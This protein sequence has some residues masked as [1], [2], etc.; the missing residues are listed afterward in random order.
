M[1]E[2][3]TCSGL[4]SYIRRPPVDLAGSRK[5]PPSLSQLRSVLVHEN[6]RKM[7]AKLGQCI[8]LFFWEPLPCGFPQ[9]SDLFRD[10]GFLAVFWGSGD[11]IRSIGALQSADC[12]GLIRSVWIS[13]FSV[14]CDTQPSAMTT[15]NECFYRTSLRMSGVWFCIIKDMIAVNDYN[16]MKI[17]S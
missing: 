9:L 4:R 5:P 10:D 14:L 12:R 13:I 8:Y 3:W 2:Y 11:R 6:S 16:W 1:W 15:A 7:V 17:S